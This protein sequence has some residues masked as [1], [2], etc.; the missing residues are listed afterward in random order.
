F[1]LI[2][3]Y[4]PPQSTDIPAFLTSLELLIIKLQTSKLDVVITGDLNINLLLKTQMVYQLTNLMR[5]YGLQQQIKAAT[6]EGDSST[7]IDH[8]YTPI[9][10]KFIISEVLKIN[11]SDHHLLYTVR[12]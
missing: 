2:T 1:F 10:S 12:V 5:C 4:R 3:I 9:N 7:L 6:R 8:I 11:I